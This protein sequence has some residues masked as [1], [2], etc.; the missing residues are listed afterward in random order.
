[1]SAPPSKPSQPTATTFNERLNEQL[2]N[3]LN[4]QTN[5]IQN[6]AQ[7]SQH[8]SLQLFEIKNIVEI[9]S[10]RVLALQQQQQQQSHFAPNHYAASYYPNYM[11][12]PPIPVS[13]PPPS[14]HLPPVPISVPQ[15]PVQ[16]RLPTTTTTTPTAN[17]PF[18]SPNATTITNNNNKY[19]TT[20][21]YNTN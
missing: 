14:S 7:Y 9:L 10:N 11:S 3:C 19:I 15:P 12:Q 20:N 13:H 17:F 1:M 5:V 18:F 6:L 4:V 16:M 2:I 8:I 21:D